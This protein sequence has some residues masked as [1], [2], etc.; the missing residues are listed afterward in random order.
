MEH[1]KE[2]YRKI[3]RGERAFYGAVIVVDTIAYTVS[4]LVSG[5]VK[6][7]SLIFWKGGKARWESLPLGC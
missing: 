2:I 4:F 1:K 5:L 6:R 3:L 7:T